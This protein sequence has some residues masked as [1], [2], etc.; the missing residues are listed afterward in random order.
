MINN[1]TWPTKSVYRNSA[2]SS[3][4][5][6]HPLM[7]RLLSGSSLRMFYFTTLAK[8]WM[9]TRWRFFSGVFQEELGLWSTSQ[10]SLWNWSLHLKIEIVFLMSIP[11][12]CILYTNTLCN[13]HCLWILP[14]FIAICEIWLPG[15]TYGL[16]LVLFLKPGATKWY[17]G[18][19]KCRTQA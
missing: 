19:A 12:D 10:L 9:G 4:L 8:S 18:N 14:L 17:Q 3:L 1:K 13:K 15:L 2:V 11:W 16:Y 5:S 6:L 7:L